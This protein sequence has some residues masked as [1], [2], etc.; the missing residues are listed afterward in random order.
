MEK[1][2]DNTGPNGT[3]VISGDDT[4]EGPAERHSTDKSC[5]RCEKYQ[6]ELVILKK[7]LTVERRKNKNGNVAFQDTREKL[8]VCKGMLESSD[9]TRV[10]NTTKYK[11]EIAALKIT[12]KA[13]LQAS[14][15]SS[16]HV[17]AAAKRS[18]AKSLL[19]V[20]HYPRPAQG[21]PG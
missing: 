11:S 8:D 15:T 7:E 4:T 6:Q 19:K 16:K 14:V 10:A 5:D 2:S 1:P 9:A 12:Q 20:R 3:R 21:H 18:E 17:D 13:A